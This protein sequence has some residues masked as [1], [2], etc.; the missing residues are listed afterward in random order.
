MRYLTLGQDEQ[1][2][3]PR[4]CRWLN[5]YVLPSCHFFHFPSTWESRGRTTAQRVLGPAWSTPSPRIA[6]SGRPMA[7]SRRPPY[8]ARKEC[9]L[10]Q[11]EG[12]VILTL[13]PA[14]AR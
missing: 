11:N 7:R 2:A 5:E 6:N 4:F 13:W 1:L 12:L 9:V 10:G 3:G 14:E 8:V